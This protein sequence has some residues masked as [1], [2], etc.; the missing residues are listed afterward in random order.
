M[1]MTIRWRHGFL[2]LAA[3]LAGCGEETKEA[4]RWGADGW[5]MGS[6]WKLVV[7]GDEARKAECVELVEATLEESVVRFST[8]RRDSELSRIN[9]GELKVE[10]ASETFRELLE[11]A[12][13]RSG[14]NPGGLRRTAR[15]VG[16]V[17]RDSRRLGR[18]PLGGKR[19]RNSTCAGSQRDSRSTRCAGN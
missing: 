8:W 6:Q 9:E 2:L 3:V 16:E 12:G 1:R 15:P 17:V 4:T 5:A 13:S 11:L 7:I 14:K 19:S 18:R 10:E